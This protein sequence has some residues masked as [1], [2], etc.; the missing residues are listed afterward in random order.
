MFGPGSL[1]VDG[2]IESNEGRREVGGQGRG[3]ERENEKREGKGE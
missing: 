1:Y 2:V 3:E